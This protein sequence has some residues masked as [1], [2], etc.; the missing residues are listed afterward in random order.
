M[1]L[2]Y[3]YAKK[4]R[5]FHDQAFNLVGCYE[6]AVRKDWSGITIKRLLPFRQK[7]PD[8]ILSLSAVVGRNATGKTNLIEMIGDK[9]R[10]GSR[11]T[12]PEEAY[13]LLYADESEEDL[14]FVEVA[15]PQEF[16][17]LFSWMGAGE[18]L[19]GW[20]RCD[21]AECRLTGFAP[22]PRANTVVVTLCERGQEHQPPLKRSF[23]N[24]HLA[25][26]FGIHIRCKAVKRL[27]S[28]P[29]KSECSQIRTYPFNRHIRA[30][31]KSSLEA[32]TKV[33]QRLFFDKEKA[34]HSV[35]HDCC[36]SLEYLYDLS[37]VEESDIAEYFP[38][39]Y[40]RFPEE[41]QVASRLIE[42]MLRYFVVQ[43]IGDLDDA[44]DLRRRFSAYLEPDT[45]EQWLQVID[46]NVDF[47]NPKSVFTDL[48][49]IIM[50]YKRET[51][52][53]LHM[54]SDYSSDN[55]LNLEKFI[56]LLLDKPD[57]LTL[58]DSSFAF[59]LPC[60]D[61]ERDFL[62][63][64]VALIDRIVQATPILN[65]LLKPVWVNI[66]DGEL[67]FIRFLAALSEEIDHRSDVPASKGFILLLDEPET[68]MH[69]DL[70]RRLLSN[71][72]TW[73][74]QYYT[75]VPVQIILTTH[76]PFLLSD[77]CSEN[78]QVLRRTSDAL[79]A[80]VSDPRMQTYAANIYSILMD[81]LI[82]DSGYGELA[83]KQIQQTMERL[84]SQERIEDDEK[85][86]IRA[87]VHHVG[88]QLVKNEL[89]NLYQA[90]YG[91]VPSGMEA[92]VAH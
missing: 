45:M 81:S 48:L 71:L 38:R 4:F 59:R 14:Y 62:M 1:Q 47:S 8:S 24:A 31:G 73:L 87:L 49:E 82:L 32:Q 18:F 88:E 17:T 60:D 5:C 2:V 16:G 11:I 41:L 12:Q 50:D 39:L 53:P 43:W 30:Y 92:E 26:R 89:S 66:S 28:S 86:D 20:C 61:Q 51:E 6:V 21:N 69:P 44:E 37:I 9:F 84:R 27:F 77:I 64:E 56:E 33:V 23:P 65:G 15:A 54:S 42:N 75:D 72:T 3:A 29:S 74:S 80:T 46:K 52:S 10:Q 7:M 78:V 55:Q 68:H 90:K 22:P 79:R 67:W 83:L 70:A 76:S 91:N 34:E 13:F 40:D 63:E 19:S 57:L 58:T 25:N 36:Y 85:A 35:L